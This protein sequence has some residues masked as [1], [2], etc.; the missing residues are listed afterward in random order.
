MSAVKDTAQQKTEEFASKAREA[1]PLRLARAPSSSARPSNES[2]C[3]SPLRERSR[4]ASSSAG[5]SAADKQCQSNSSAHLRINPIGRG[6]PE[7]RISRAI[8]RVERGRECSSGPG[9][10]SSRQSDRPFGRLDV[11]RRVGDLP[12][13]I[14]LVSILGLIGHSVTQPLIENLGRSHQGRP[15]GSSPAQSRTSN[16]AGFGGILFVVGLAVALWSASSYVAAFMRRRTSSGTWRRAGR[17]G[18]PPVRVGVTFNRR[19]ADAERHSGRAHRSAGQGRRQPDRHRSIGRHDL[20]YREMAGAAADC[21]ADAGD[22][23]LRRPEREAARLP[24]GD[25][26]GVLA[27]LLWVLASAA[28]AF[29]VANFPRTTRPMGHWPP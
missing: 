23:L 27:V 25:P 22:P 17:S 24:L 10:S 3:R 12:L 28:F 8:F 6:R 13:L 16:P 11:L 21:R 19:P 7:S 29:Y 18:D 26:G 9:A 4:G 15:G 14:V 2:R 20:G 1:A 5:S